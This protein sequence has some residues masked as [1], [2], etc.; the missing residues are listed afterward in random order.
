M[1]KFRKVRRKANG[2]KAALQFSFVNLL[3]VLIAGGIILLIMYSFADTAR[4]ATID[5]FC[6]LSAVTKA[7]FGVIGFPELCETRIYN[8]D[9]F[10]RNKCHWD[11]LEEKYPTRSIGKM[12]AAEQVVDL[13]ARC[14][15]IRG[16]SYFD[17]GDFQCFGFVVN[18]K[19]SFDFEISEGVLKDIY[20]DPDLKVSSI[21]GD[22]SYKDILPRDQDKYFWQN[23]DLLIRT[24]SDTT[25]IRRFTTRNN[26]QYK[27]CFV[28]NWKSDP[29]SKSDVLEIRQQTNCRHE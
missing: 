4:D 27:I 26:L 20:S 8:I 10:A 7:K 15:N 22:K 14:W 25:H 16:S 19:K 17:P 29:F 21:A 5:N 28:D 11:Y 2:K 13:L 18:S 6:K 24:E 9:P 1:A 23:N 12:C 3:L